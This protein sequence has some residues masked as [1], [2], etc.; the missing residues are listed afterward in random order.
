MEQCR[1]A[2]DPVG[3]PVE[4]R[5]G[6]GHRA[7]HVSRAAEIV[8]YGSRGA[9]QQQGVA[10]AVYADR[11]PG[12]N[13]FGRDRRVALH[14]LADEE[15]RG[16][17]LPGVESLEYRRSAAEVRPVVEGER[18]PAPSRKRA[19]NLKRCGD[20]ACDGSRRGSE[21]RHRDRARQKVRSHA[22]P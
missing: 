20:R 11:V 13:D 8:A 16:N 22:L 5:I 2:E 12:G 21:P 19:R 4:V 15:E 6:A 18:D 17:C 9:S 7:D 1:A 10:V 14:L 3:R